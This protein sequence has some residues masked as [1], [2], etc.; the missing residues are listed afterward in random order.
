MKTDSIPP[1]T[2]SVALI[3]NHPHVVAKQGGKTQTYPCTTM[4]EA[5]LVKVQVAEFLRTRRL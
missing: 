2:V 3:D 4:T 5:N 1:T